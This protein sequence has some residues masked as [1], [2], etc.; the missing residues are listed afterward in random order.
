MP[1]DPVLIYISFVDEARQPD[2]RLGSKGDMRRRP[3]HF[4]FT[5]RAD[6][7]RPLRHVRFVR[8]C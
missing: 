3:D 8:L 5:P 4:C 7:Q 6:I 1:T 2:D